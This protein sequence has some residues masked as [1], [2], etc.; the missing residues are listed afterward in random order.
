MFVCVCVRA[1]VRACVRVC[2][3]R[4]FIF[5]CNI[6]AAGRGARFLL[7]FS[8]CVCS[9]VYFSFRWFHLFWCSLCLNYAWLILGNAFDLWREPLEALCAVGVL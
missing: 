9:L 4:E 2:A 3:P 1:C 8:H 7:Q 6:R 5:F